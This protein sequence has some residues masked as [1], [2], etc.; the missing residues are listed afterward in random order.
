MEHLFATLHGSCLRSEQTPTDFRR[1]S[2]SIIKSRESY[3]AKLR[4][5]GQRFDW[6]DS[7]LTKSLFDEVHAF[8]ASTPQVSK[9]ADEMRPNAQIGRG[10]HLSLRDN[11]LALSLSVR[12]HPQRRA[13]PKR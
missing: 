4:Y 10:C 8:L 6:S 11:Y 1:A 7:M 3:C 5:T 12:R 13:P 2:V 9:T